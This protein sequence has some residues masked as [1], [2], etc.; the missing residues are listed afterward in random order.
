MIAQPLNDGI[1]RSAVL[2]ECGLYRYSLM[3]RLADQ[4]WHE[5]LK[6]GIVVWV[7]NNPST[8]DGTGDDP[9]VRK[10]WKYT[11]GWGYSTMEF[12]NTNPWRATDPKLAEMPP[13][14]ALVINDEWLKMAMENAAVTIAAW[15]DKANPTLARRAYGVIHGLGPVY[16]MRVTKAGNP[17]HPLYLPGDT[18]PQLWK[19]DAYLN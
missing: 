7:L 11:V 12:I 5:H 18:R 10:C 15:G 16:S 17:Q 19:A 13:E 2:S 3:R 4:L 9:T 6:P 14:Q 8:A 1:V